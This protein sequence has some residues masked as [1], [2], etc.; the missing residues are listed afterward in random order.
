MNDIQIEKLSQSI[1][2]PIKKA[3]ENCLASNNYQS[4]CYCPSFKR[5][6]NNKGLG[7]IL[8]TI[9]KN[10]GLTRK[11]I[12]DTLFGSPYHAAFSEAFQIIKHSKTAIYRK[13][14]KG[15]FITPLGLAILRENSIIK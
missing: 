5:L 10:P 12:L 8:F 11:E 2:N 14:L 9:A 3:I 7:G 4:N 13:D 1:V 15:H 6:K